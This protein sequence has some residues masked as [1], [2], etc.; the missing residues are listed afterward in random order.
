[1]LVLGVI[2]VVALGVGLGVGLGLKRDDAA[3]QALNQDGGSSGGRVEPS[4]PA[5]PSVPN[6]NGGGGGSSGGGTNQPPVSLSDEGVPI[7]PRTEA[8]GNV[9]PTSLS[10]SPVLPSPAGMITTVIVARQAR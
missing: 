6:G 8:L 5:F 7:G 1:M 4:A 10:P 3:T 2:A 9:V